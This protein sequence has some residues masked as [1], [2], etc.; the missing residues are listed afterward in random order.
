ME[1]GSSENL[2]SV[3]GLRWEA[4]CD[5][6]QKK[7]EY[8]V[9]DITPWNEH[10]EEGWHLLCDTDFCLGVLQVEPPELASRLE[11]IVRRNINAASAKHAATY[12]HFS[13]ANRNNDDT[14]GGYSQW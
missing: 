2:P 3:E 5:D 7:V 4:I 12:A 8:T 1:T 6:C 10:A 9:Y 14:T 11:K 13:D